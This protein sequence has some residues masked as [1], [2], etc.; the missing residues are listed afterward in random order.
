MPAR[1]H[2]RPSGASGRAKLVSGTSSTRQTSGFT[3]SRPA[4]IDWYH[5]PQMIRRLFTLSSVAPRVV[6]VLLTG[7]FA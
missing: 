7:R 2:R 1:T 4:S 6:T 5:A 3:I